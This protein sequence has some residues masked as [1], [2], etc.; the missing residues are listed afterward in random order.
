MQLV[1]FPSTSMGEVEVC[2]THVFLPS[3]SAGRAAG[4]AAGRSDRKV[5]N[6]ARA[7]PD[8]PLGQGHTDDA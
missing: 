5:G 2:C 6:V 3:A 1:N 4:R 8:L 7:L